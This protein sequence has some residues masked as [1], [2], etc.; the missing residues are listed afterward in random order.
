MLC[1]AGWPWVVPQT[2]FLAPSLNKSQRRPEGSPMASRTRRETGARRPCNIDMRI[3]TCLN[4][5]MY[6][7]SSSP[8]LEL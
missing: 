3:E 2:Q 1:A 4:G 6:A 8:S 5:G 7:S